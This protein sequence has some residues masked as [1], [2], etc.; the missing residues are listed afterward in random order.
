MFPY[1]EE[2]TVTDPAPQD[3]ACITLAQLHWQQKLEEDQA[4][5]ILSIQVME[6]KYKP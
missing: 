3:A 5:H 1:L 4:L 2:A 6:D